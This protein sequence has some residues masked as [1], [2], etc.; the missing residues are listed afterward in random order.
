MF[1]T[2]EFKQMFE[3]QEMKRLGCSITYNPRYSYD[4][5]D[6]IYC[7]VNQDCAS[8]C[9]HYN[10]CSSECNLGLEWLWWTLSFFLFFCCI[11]SIIAGA[12]RRRM[13]ALR[14]QQRRNHSD[15]S[16]EDRAAVIV[17]Q[18]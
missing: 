4:L 17:V 14:A 3:A 10:Y 15:E 13:M 2:T 1:E 18:Q 8:N 16:C 12:R 11:F 9:C 6:G 5:C 7:Q